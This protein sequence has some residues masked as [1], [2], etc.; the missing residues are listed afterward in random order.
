[1]RFPIAIFQTLL[2]FEANCSA[3][4]NSNPTGLCKI[5]DC[6]V[7]FAY[8]DCARCGG[9][10]ETLCEDAASDR[11]NRRAADRKDLYVAA[12]FSGLRARISRSSHRSRA[13]RER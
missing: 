8:V 7:Y 6:V 13:G 10:A 2:F 11:P 12:P 1:M 3:I 5:C 4:T 9:P